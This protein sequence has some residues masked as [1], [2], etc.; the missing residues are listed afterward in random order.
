MRARPPWIWGSGTPRREFLHCA[1]LARAGLFLLENFS[2][3]GPI[4]VGVG[5]DI[6]IRDLALLMR[7]IVGFE[8]ELEFDLS[9]PDGTPRKLMDVSRINAL[10]WRAE[11]ELRAG[12]GETYAW[13][14]ENVGVLV[15][16]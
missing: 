14:R 12:V 2:Q 13:F 4:N 6:S 3:S 8:G 7:E 9:K 5:E 15:E 1:D 16:R 11:V 10:G